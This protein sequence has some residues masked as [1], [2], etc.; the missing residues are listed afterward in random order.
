MSSHDPSRMDKKKDS[1]YK[2]PKKEKAKP[3]KKKQITDNQIQITEYGIPHLHGTDRHTVKYGLRYA[4]DLTFTYELCHTRDETKLIY[5]K[6]FLTCTQCA[7]L[8]SPSTMKYT[9]TCTPGARPLSLPTRQHDAMVYKSTHKTGYTQQS[10]IPLNPI[11]SDCIIVNQIFADR[12]TTQTQNMQHHS[13]KYGESSFCT[14]SSLHVSQYQY[15]PR[16]RAT[17]G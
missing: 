14:L 9:C 3:D 1:L 10:S 11:E 16:K 6:N 4:K 8:F 17:R 12:R 7:R 2:Y 5:A 13:C 15:G